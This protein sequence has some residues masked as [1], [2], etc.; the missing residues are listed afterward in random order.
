MDS[1]KKKI[2]FI[3]NPVSGIGRQRI[4]ERLAK[5]YLDKEKFDYSFAYSEYAGHAIEIAKQAVDEQLDIVVAVGGDGSVNEVVSSIVNTPLALAV[6]PTGSGNGLAHHLK[7]PL[8][9]KKALKVINNNKTISIDTASFQ[10]KTF[11]SVSGVGF[12]AKIAQ[13]FSQTKLRGFISYL[14]LVIRE[15]FMYKPLEYS[16]L[17]DGKELQSKALFVTFANSNQ[18]GYNMKVSPKASLTDGLLDVCIMQKF[19]PWYTISIIYYIIMG[20]MNH[21][22]YLRIYQA[23]KVRVKCEAEEMT[24][25]DGD[26]LE[27][28]VDIKVEI[29]PASLK[30]IVP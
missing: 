13:E 15:Y 4:V 10:G 28:A 14:R 11:A 17:L 20:K 21:C 2:L 18:F 24:H 27:I 23:K 30:V 25:I 29:F 8:A 12:D 6:I 19:P 22:K 26:P 3:I 9:V 1:L 7:I 16:F 5:Q